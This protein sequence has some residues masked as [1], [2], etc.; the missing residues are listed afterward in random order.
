MEAAKYL[1]TS[2]ECDREPSELRKHITVFVMFV[3]T[4]KWFQNCMK[5]TVMHATF[6]LAGAG[7]NI[8][9]TS[10]TQD[11]HAGSQ[12]CP[13]SKEISDLYADEMQQWLRDTEDI[14][15]LISAISGPTI[16]ASARR[17]KL[18]FRRAAGTTLL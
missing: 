2:F 18:K 7:W 13:V 17:P 8:Q 10:L 15:Y 14:P 1:D 12:R 4:I 5:L 16:C 9:A 6:L 3:A 11:L